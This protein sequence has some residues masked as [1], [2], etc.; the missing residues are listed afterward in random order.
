MALALDTP[1]PPT[2]FRTSVK[3]EQPYGLTVPLKEHQ[4]AMLH[5]CMEIEKLA[6]MSQYRVGFM[7]DTV[8]VI[9]TDSQCSAWEKGLGLGLESKA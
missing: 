3:A 7:A 8:K 9:G 1:L 5:R 2:V 4:L 6:I